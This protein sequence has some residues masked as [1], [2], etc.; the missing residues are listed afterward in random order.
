MDST[1]SSSSF[2]KKRLSDMVYT[3]ITYR[4]KG[5]QTLIIQSLSI[6]LSVTILFLLSQVYLIFLPCLKALLWAL[7]CGSALYPFKIRLANL[8][9]EWLDQLDRTN[10]SLCFGCLMLPM[11]LTIMLY[12]RFI[13]LMSNNLVLFIV[14]HFRYQI[15][16][17]IRRLFYRLLPMILSMPMA[18]DGH[19]AAIIVAIIVITIHAVIAMCTAPEHRSLLRSMPTVL[20]MTFIYLLYYHLGIFGQL[21][22][23]FI[24]CMFV[25]GLIA[26]GYNLFHGSSELQVNGLIELFR[27]NIRIKIENYVTWIRHKPVIHQTIV[28]DFGFRRSRTHERIEP[29]VDYC[30]CTSDSSADVC[31]A[32][33][34]LI[35]VGLGNS[36]DLLTS[37]G[38]FMIVGSM[39]TFSAVFVSIKIYGECYQTIYLLQNE[40]KNIEF[41]QEIIKQISEPHYIDNLINDRLNLQDDEKIFINKMLAEIRHNILPW[42]NPNNSSSSTGTIEHESISAVESLGWLSLNQWPKLWRLVDYKNFGDL[43]ELVRTQ[44]SSYLPMVKSIIS[45]SYAFI[46]VIL[47][48]ST[49]LMSFVFNFIIFLLALFYLLSSSQNKYKP[50]ELIDHMVASLFISNQEENR[51]SHYVEQ[52]VNS[53]FAA[54]IKISAFYGVYTWLLH[55]LFALRI[56]YI[57]SAIAAI[58]AAVPLLNAYW[59]SLPACIYLYFFEGNLALVKSLSMFGLAMLP[60]FMVD[61]SIYSDIGK[62]GHP[63][64]TGLAITCGVL[65][66]GVEGAL[67]GPLWLCLL[68]IIVNMCTEMDGRN[69][70]SPS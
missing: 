38:L 6:L 67:F 4:Q 18:K 13:D 37:I 61:S 46:F 29:G 49:M 17:Q 40:L 58:L 11:Q 41:I 47:D 12:N 35:K 68:V 50:I 21:T 62:G 69:M 20:L 42:L 54:T 5:V 10:R 57:P 56:C 43:I 34:R 19:F 70:L 15:V 22:L 45:V 48:S 28:Y 9:R 32:C 33:D 7:L 31:F 65:Y 2:V 60:S 39:V 51:F 1:P 3:W 16:N 55:S 27:D 64:L 26:T 59:A 44:A 53:I 23:L 8:L 24:V 25:I 36:L 14:F 52:V 66:Y 63:Y 30:A